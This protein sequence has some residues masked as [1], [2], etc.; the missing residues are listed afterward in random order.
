MGCCPKDEGMGC[1]P[2]DEGMGGCPKDEGMGGCTKEG[3]GAW[4]AT[5]VAIVSACWP[6]TFF[7]AAAR[8]ALL[9]LTNMTSL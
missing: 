2:K 4:A 3:K 1:C 7:A 6:L 9:A 5:V 8:D